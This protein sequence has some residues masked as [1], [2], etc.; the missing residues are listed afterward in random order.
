VVWRSKADV[1]L[2]LDVKSVLRA[3][4]FNLLF[5]FVHSFG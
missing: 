4:V 2:K 5:Y 3:F 1:D